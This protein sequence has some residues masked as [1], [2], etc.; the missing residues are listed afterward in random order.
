MPDIQVNK[1]TDSRKYLGSFLEQLST[2][3]VRILRSCPPRLP[4]LVYV[5][6]PDHLNIVLSLMVSTM[7]ALSCARSAGHPFSQ[8]I[9]K[10][11]TLSISNKDLLQSANGSF[12][13]YSSF[14]TVN[15]DWALE[16]IK[17]SLEF[18]GH[19]SYNRMLMDV[20]FWCQMI[21]T[22]EYH[23]DKTLFLLVT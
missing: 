1:L 4:I 15:L 19:L 13:Q 14:S 16:T 7:S 20:V 21:L 22:V 23:S 9:F 11:S 3:C 10:E 5:C 12:D 2:V 8:N 18:R 17:C 6:T